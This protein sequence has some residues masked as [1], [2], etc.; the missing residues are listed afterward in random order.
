MIRIILAILVLLMIYDMYTTFTKSNLKYEYFTTDEAIANIASL[1]NNKSLITTDLTATGTTKLGNVTA[2]NITGVN[3][4]FTG[5]VIASTIGSSDD[6]FVGRSAV[7]DCS[8]PKAAGT[9]YGSQTTLY[10]STDKCTQMC[11][12]G[13]VMVGI[14]NGDDKQD[15][16]PLCRWTNK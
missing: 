10:S 6:V 9:S 8:K 12:P 4:K 2:S 14:L 3:G 1:Y 13:S 16:H 5:P 15:H 11:P 7:G